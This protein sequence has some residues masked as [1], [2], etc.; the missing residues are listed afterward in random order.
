MILPARACQ[1]CTYRISKTHVFG[2]ILHVFCAKTPP[3]RPH[4]AWKTPP[5]CIRLKCNIC[6]GTADSGQY[7]PL[8][9]SVREKTHIEKLFFI[10]FPPIADIA[11]ALQ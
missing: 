7:K 10:L 2:P 8:R 3:K 11:G 6:S 5:K 9:E 4:N 1:K